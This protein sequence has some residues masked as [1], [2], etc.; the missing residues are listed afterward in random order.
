MEFLKEEIYHQKKKKIYSF[1]KNDVN[2]FR[3][4]FKLV[5]KREEKNKEDDQKQGETKKKSEKKVKIH[6]KLLQKT[7]VF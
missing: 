7:D 4:I 2:I 6:E 1:T 3:E 5:K